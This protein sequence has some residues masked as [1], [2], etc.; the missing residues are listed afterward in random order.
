MQ[1]KTTEN[2]R[3]TATRLAKINS[4]CGFFCC[5]CLICGQRQVRKE[6]LFCSPELIV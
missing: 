3:F 1:I 2:S 4:T 5:C 6:I